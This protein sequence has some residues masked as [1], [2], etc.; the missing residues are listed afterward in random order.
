MRRGPTTRGSP[1][2]EFSLDRV[3]NVLCL[4]A[5]SDDIEIG[6]GGTLLRLMRDYT[7][8]NVWWVVFS[9]KGTRSREARASARAFL[10]GAG[11][12]KIVVKEFRDGFFPYHADRIKESFE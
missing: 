3:K 6:C 4:G 9:G 12:S 11:H 7:S 2:I 10:T 8:L 1:M 5:H